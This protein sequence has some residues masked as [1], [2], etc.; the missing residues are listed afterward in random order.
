M[1]TDV[2]VIGS[3][4]IGLWSAFRAAERGARVTVVDPSPGRGASWTAAGMLAPVTEYGY[5]ED[6]LLSLT[7]AAAAGYPAAVADLAAA[8]GRDPGYRACGAIEVAWDAADLAGLR[9]LNARRA[10]LGLESNLLTGRELRRLE[11]GLAPGLPGGVFA[12][13]DHQ[14]DNRRMLA[15]L[16]TAVAAAGVRVLEQAVASVTVVDGR[17]RGVVLDD[18]SALV[19]GAVVLAAGAHSGRLPGVPGRLRPPV[20]PVKG[21]TLRLRSVEPIVRR[22]VRGRVRGVPVYVVPRADGE[23]VIGASSEEAGFDV[24]PR[25]GAVHDL[26]RDALLLVPG[27][28]EARWGEV[29]TGLRPGTPDNGPVVGVTDVDGLVLAT[30]HHRNGVLLAPLTGAAVAAVLA[31]EPVPDVLRPFGPDRFT[32]RT[33]VPSGGSA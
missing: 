24:S 31:D 13:D 33:L 26:L 17:C 1:D 21:Q 20:R 25:A 2:V 14:I 29:S 19:G 28:A 7:L 11:P 3:G 5:G 15:A 9:D 4:V 22:T 6:A 8:S 18:G 12:A 16:F 32:A 10:Q 30:G 27:L 23:I